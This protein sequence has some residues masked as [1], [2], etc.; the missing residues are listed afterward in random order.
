LEKMQEHALGVARIEGGIGEGQRSRVGHLVLDPRAH[1]RRCRPPIGVRDR[2]GIGVDPVDATGRP[3]QPRQ[4]QGVR[5]DPAAD[6]QHALP[7]AHKQQL[8]D[9]PL[10]LGAHLCSGV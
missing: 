6:I 3:D 8:V 4:W 1:P 2:R 9:M 10:A 5:P 7:R